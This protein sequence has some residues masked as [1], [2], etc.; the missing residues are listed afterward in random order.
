MGVQ[1]L[2]TTWSFRTCARDRSVSTTIVVQLEAGIKTTMGCEYFGSS[3]KRHD[4]GGLLE[5]AV[6]ILVGSGEKS[7]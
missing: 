3:A 2:K 1:T 6:V 4:G 5:L 7:P